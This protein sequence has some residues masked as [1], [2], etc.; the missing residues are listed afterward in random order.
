MIGGQVSRDAPNS[1]LTCCQRHVRRRA[2]VGVEIELVVHRQLRR[3]EAIGIHA[4][5]ASPI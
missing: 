2:R 3:R 4:S 1:S 5:A